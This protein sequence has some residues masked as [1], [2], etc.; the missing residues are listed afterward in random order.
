MQL[1]ARVN[2]AGI[3][4]SGVRT[5]RFLGTVLGFHILGEIVRDVSAALDMT[6]I[7]AKAL[8]WIWPLT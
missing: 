1:A 5:L 4:Q 3:R 8:V 6:E 2:L 7:E